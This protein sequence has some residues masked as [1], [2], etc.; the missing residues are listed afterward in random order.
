MHPYDAQAWNLKG[1]ILGGDE[2]K[3]ASDR[4][5]WIW[6]NHLENPL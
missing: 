1:E 5:S 3:K 6:N 2:G 4:A